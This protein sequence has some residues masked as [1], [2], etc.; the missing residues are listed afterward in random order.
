M[1]CFSFMCKECGK[2]VHST[3]QRGDVVKLFLLEDGEV[4]Q[5]M[6]GEYDSYGRVFRAGNKDSIHWDMEWQ[7]VCDLMFDEDMGNGI[8]AIHSECFTGEIPT[9]RSADD[10]NQGWGEYD[11]DDEDD[12]DNEYWED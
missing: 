6:E 1:G 8:A 12:E 10:P 11:E 7:D 4:V 2:A 9:T 3:S 5:N